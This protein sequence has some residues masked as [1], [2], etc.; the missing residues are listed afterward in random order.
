MAVGNTAAAKHPCRHKRSNCMVSMDQV[1][2]SCHAGVFKLSDCIQLR[3]VASV[4]S[5][6]T[7]RALA[8]A[9]WTPALSRLAA[10]R[11][12]DGVTDGT[13]LGDALETAYSQLLFSGHFSLGSRL[14]TSASVSDT[15]R[16]ALTI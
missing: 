1:L 4:F 6:P 8:Q 3:E 10:L 2:R 9:Q 7:Y 12:V 13:L 15:T 5:S 14:K 11:E 16:S